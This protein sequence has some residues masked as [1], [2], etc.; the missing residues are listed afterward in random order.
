MKKASALLLLLSLVLSLT[1]CMGE[2]Y[3][4]EEEDA[5]RQRGEQMMREW[6]DAKYPGAE[7]ASVEPYIWHNLGIS[8][9]KLTDTVSGTF[10]CGD[11]EQKYWLDTA[12][13]IVYFERDDAAEA[14]EELCASCAAEALG[15]G[16]CEADGGT[17]AYIDISAT[18]ESGAPPNVLPADFV[19]SGASLESF[20]RSPQGRPAITVDAVYR[21]PDGFDVSGVTLERAQR[22]LGDYGLL[23]RCTVK[24]GSEEAVL[25][26]DRAVYT[27]AEFRDLPDFR[28]WMPVYE[29]EE[30]LDKKT[31]EVKTRIVEREI[32]RDLTVERGEDGFYKPN[33]PN[34]WFHA[35]VYAYDGSEMLRHTY[36]YVS[37]NDRSVELDWQETER[38]WRLGATDTYLSESHPFRELS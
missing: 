35:L 34:G 28:V 24:S 25:K 4:D 16:G 38:G 1:G 27:R 8:A 10:R 32:G 7:L 14:L 13:G 5:V 36:Y 11:G 30:S 21:V 19:L 6:L 9:Y 20:V 22:V 18:T 33:F 26:A 37:D 23:L 3:T 17:R 2:R 31:G 15:L 12:S 29:R